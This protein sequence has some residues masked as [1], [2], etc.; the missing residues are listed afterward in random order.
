MSSSS[1]AYQPPVAVTFGRGQCLELPEFG[2][3]QRVG[4]DITKRLKLR[5]RLALYEEDDPSTQKK[6]FWCGF[7]LPP[8]LWIFGAVLYANTP[9]TKVLAR[10]AGWRNVVCAIGSSLVLSLIYA[11][12]S[13]SNATD[14]RP[15]RAGSHQAGLSY[16]R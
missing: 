13:V 1:A 12:V 14:D 9:K 16:P 6:L 15:H 3:E 7:F 4:V 10:E 8:V 5:D 2:G 11:A